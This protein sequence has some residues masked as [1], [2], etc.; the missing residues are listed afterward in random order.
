MRNIDILHS[1]YHQLPA[2]AELLQVIH[3]SSA[4]G[5]V[6]QQPLHGAILL[7]PQ[8]LNASGTA[9]PTS[10]LCLRLVL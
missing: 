2:A 1:V 5:A 4:P 8:H 3:S 7:H 6:L 10:D 9:D